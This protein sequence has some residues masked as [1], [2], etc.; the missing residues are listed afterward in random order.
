M[1]RPA[2][3]DTRPMHITAC[4]TNKFRHVTYHFYAWNINNLSC[5]HYT[6]PN[7]MHSHTF[8]SSNSLHN[9]CKCE[10]LRAPHAHGSTRRCKACWTHAAAA[11]R[12]RRR[13]KQQSR[14]CRRSRRLSRL[15]TITNSIRSP[16][17]LQRLGPAELLQHSARA[18]HVSMSM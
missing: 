1:S 8:F 15:L 5:E 18:A 14:A 12:C 10:F 16:L 11:E 13:R 2:K 9:L 3:P 17:V 6:K 4:N 7:I